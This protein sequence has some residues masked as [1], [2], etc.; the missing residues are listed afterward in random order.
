MKNEIKKELEQWSP[1]LSKM[2]GKPEG[3]SVPDGYFAKMESELLDLLGPELKAETATPVPPS[4]A[5]SFWNNLLGQ[6][7]WL[8]RPRMAMRLAG[9]AMLFIA[10]L[11]L[12][13]DS[14]TVKPDALAGLTAE[15]ATEYLV[16]HLDEFDTETLIEFA[17]DTDTPLSVDGNFFNSSEMDNLF[18][19]MDEENID[20]ETLEGLL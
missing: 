10:G 3:F 1:M 13:P 15:D 8:L 16:A 20:L 5:P 2:K 7:G 11:L 19:V 18:D 6:M 4:P 9:V 12:L 14:N 17:L